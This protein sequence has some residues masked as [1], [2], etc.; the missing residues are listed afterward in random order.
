MS[1]VEL[2]LGAAAVNREPKSGVDKLP[3]HTRRTT[4][5]VIPRTGWNFVSLQRRILGVGSMMMLNMGSEIL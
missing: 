1:T 4:T 3:S 5:G 2:R